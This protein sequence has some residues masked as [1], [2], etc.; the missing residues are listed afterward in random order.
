[1]EE[2][3]TLKMAGFNILLVEDNEADIKI[4]QRAF[5]KVVFDNQLFVVKDGE[6][7]VEY[8]E[9][10]GAFENLKDYKKIDLILLDINMPKLNGFDVLL[11]IKANRELIHIPVI[12]LTS[13]QNELDILKSYQLGAASFIQKPIDFNQFLEIVNMFN[14]YWH[15]CVKLPKKIE[16][17]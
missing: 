1:M 8:L 13:S 9:Q 7:A 6:A 5:G 10:K 3:S 11:K 2:K 17:D 12:V 4:T 15:V 14:N 16:I